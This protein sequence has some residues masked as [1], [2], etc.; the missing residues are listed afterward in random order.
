MHNRIQPSS[1]GEY[2]EVSSGILRM[3]S[4]SDSEQNQSKAEPANN[5]LRVRSFPVSSLPAPRR[6]SSM[7]PS[8]I[9]PYSRCPLKRTFH[10]L[11]PPDTS[12]ATDH[13]LL[14]KMLLALDSC[15]VAGVEIVRRIRPTRSGRAILLGL[16]DRSIIRAGQSLRVVRWIEPTPSLVLLTKS[17]YPGCPGFRLETFSYYPKVRDC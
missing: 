13:A 9:V 11:S 16:P 2:E 1:P 3:S 8:S 12:C 4:G 15:R 17:T 6:S 10:V 5:L 14:T 7:S